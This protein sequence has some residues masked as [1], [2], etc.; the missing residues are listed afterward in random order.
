MTFKEYFKD[1]GGDFYGYDIRGTVGQA[2]AIIWEYRQIEIDKLKAENKVMKD[3]LVPMAKGSHK[4]KALYD[5]WCKE[6]EE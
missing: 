3:I 1:N 2:C 4:N 5:W 6:E